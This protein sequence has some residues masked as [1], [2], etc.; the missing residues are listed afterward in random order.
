MRNRFGVCFHLCSD[1]SSGGCE[2]IA[3]VKGFGASFGE[4]RRAVV[5]APPASKMRR[6]GTTVDRFGSIGSFESLEPYATAP[7]MML[8][9]G[10]SFGKEADEAAI[11]RAGA[12]EADKDDWLVTSGRKYMNSCRPM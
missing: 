10:G 6:A 7:D 2:T 8:D 4:V 1:G 12:V 5:N 11:I 9:S 3:P